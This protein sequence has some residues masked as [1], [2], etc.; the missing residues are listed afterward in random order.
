MQ[1][2][3]IIYYFTAFLIVPIHRFRCVQHIHALA[4]IRWKWFVLFFCNICNG[5]PALCEAPT[6]C[7]C[8]DNTN[9]LTLFPDHTNN[10]SYTSDNF[11][12]LHPC[13][14]TQLGN[15]AKC[16]SQCAHWI[17]DQLYMCWI[18]QAMMC[19]IPVWSLPKM[20][21]HWQINCFID[22][23]STFQSRINDSCCAVCLYHIR[24]DMYGHVLCDCWHNSFSIP[25]I[26][27]ATAV[28]QC[29]HNFT[30]CV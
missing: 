2:N 3:I 1:L 10:E 22:N 7:S 20:Q 25:D 23:Q 11:I 30:L 15:V 6:G 13:L 12:I 24:I 28:E 29:N 14:A 27:M 8:S 21:T 17:V 5:C 19:S 18:C 9:P 16:N 4:H 26:T